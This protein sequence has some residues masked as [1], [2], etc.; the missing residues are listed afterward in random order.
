MGAIGFARSEFAEP[1]LDGFVYGSAARDR[2]ELF[3]ERRTSVCGLDLSVI[4][5]V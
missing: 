4:G 2:S 5:D 1:L 3:P